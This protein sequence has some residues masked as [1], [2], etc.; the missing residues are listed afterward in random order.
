MVGVGDVVYVVPWDCVEIA[1]GCHE[2][3][4]G[5]SPDDVKQGPR[6]SLETWPNFADDVYTAS[7]EE[8]YRKVVGRPD[9][10]REENQRTVVR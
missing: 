6:F 1:P 7:V 8:Y 3:R 10:P 4:L 9:R 2:L 5:L